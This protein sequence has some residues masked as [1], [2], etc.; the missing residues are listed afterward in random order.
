MMHESCYSKNNSKSES[1]HY[2]SIMN[3]HLPA[4]IL[5]LKN[6]GAVFATAVYSQFTSG[7]APSWFEAM[8]TDAQSFVLLDYLPNWMSEP[9]TLDLLAMAS[10]ASRPTGTAEPTTTSSFEPVPE[11]ASTK[12]APILF[13]AIF[14]PMI[15]LAFAL[16]FAVWFIRRR[17]KRRAISLASNLPPLDPEQAVRRWSETTFSTALQPQDQRSP[18]IVSPSMTL[19]HSPAAASLPLRRALSESD[20]GH[21]MSSATKA[22]EL[23][24]VATQDDPAELE[25]RTAPLVRC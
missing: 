24:C 6:Q 13:A 19:M 22:T 18:S 12:K 5:M 4:A 8:P 14:V 25:T 9:M 21:S 3:E 23:E 2:M 20:L 16:G 1:W 17:R 10:P 7:T 11:R 15:S